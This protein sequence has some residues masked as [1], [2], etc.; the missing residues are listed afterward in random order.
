[1]MA[2]ALRLILGDQLTR[3]LSSLKDIDPKKIM[4]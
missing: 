1:M 2:G 3:G 4:S